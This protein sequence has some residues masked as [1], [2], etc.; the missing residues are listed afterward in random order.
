MAAARRTTSVPLTA[1]SSHP[2]DTVMRI[3]TMLFEG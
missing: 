3:A 2:M 1:S